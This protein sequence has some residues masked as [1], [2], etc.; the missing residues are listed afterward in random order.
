MFKTFLISAISGL[1]FLGSCAEPSPE[2]IFEQ[3]ITSLEELQAASFTAS[4]ENKSISSEDT[5][6][7]SA[8]VDFIRVASDSIYGIH[9]NI[10]SKE[11]EYKH[12]SN[13]FSFTNH[14]NKYVRI[15]N[16]LESPRLNKMIPILIIPPNLTQNKIHFLDTD[17]LNFTLKSNMP[18]QWVIEFSGFIEDTEVFGIYKIDKKSMYPLDI[19]IRRKSFD[20]HSYYHL[21]LSE[22]V[23]KTD[24][25]ELNSGITFYEGYDVRYYPMDSEKLVHF[26]SSPAPNFSLIST[27]NDTVTLVQ[28]LGQP[29]LLDFWEMWCAPCLKA[30]PKVDSFATIYSQM[31]LITLGIV[32]SKPSTV[33]KFID[34]KGYSFTNLHSNKIITDNFRIRGN[35]TYVLISKEGNI[36]HKAHELSSDFILKIDA[37]LK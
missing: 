3:S 37:E 9:F 34:E 8:T 7:L 2:N 16:P 36:V 5:F 27:S 19:E 26:T 12:T 13:I 11:Y 22:I 32:S 21:T 1:F 6:K 29:V 24:V 18:N 31:G 23:E 17:S 14:I 28:F 15:A 4:L 33:R 35:P 20:S 10:V 25:Q 30:M